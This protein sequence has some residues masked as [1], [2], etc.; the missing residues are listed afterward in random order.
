MKQ[1]IANITRFLT[2]QN[3]HHDMQ[4]EILS[5]Y[6]KMMKKQKYWFLY[7]C[8]D[9]KIIYNE[10]I[11]Y[12]PIEEIDLINLYKFLYDANV[13]DN[14]PDWKMLKYD[15]NGY[16]TRYYCQN[17]VVERE[18]KDLLHLLKTN[19]S[20]YRYEFMVSIG[21]YERYLWSLN[22]KEIEV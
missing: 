7:I 8:S 14:D 21:K 9:N 4:N 2:K 13:K 16:T 6:Q 15:K 18:T 5:Y 11:Q 12:L 1:Q 22:L 10:T 19:M 3:I 20:M 17:R